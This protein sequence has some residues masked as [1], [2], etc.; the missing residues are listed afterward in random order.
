VIDWLDAMIGTKVS[1]ELESMNERMQIQKV[2]E[3]YRTLPSIAMRRHLDKIQSPQCVI[4]K[5]TVTAHFTATWAPERQDFEKALAD[6]DVDL[7]QKIPAEGPEEMEEY[8][9]DRNTSG[10]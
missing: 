6:T 9:G 10:T 3:A 8:I 7:D 5:E 2:R 4:G 1:G